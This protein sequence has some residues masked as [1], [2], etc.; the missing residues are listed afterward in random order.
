[1]RFRAFNADP[2]GQWVLCFIEREQGLLRSSDG[3]SGE[4][5]CDPSYRS[6]HRPVGR[7]DDGSSADSG[8]PD[9][10]PWSGLRG[11]DRST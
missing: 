9:L 11:S 6:Q 2:G 8:Y 4:Q 3:A 1:M 7:S 10:S 5:I